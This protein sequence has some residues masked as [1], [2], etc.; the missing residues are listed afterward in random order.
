MI[1]SLERD[2][3][4]LS[5]CARLVTTL[6]QWKLRIGTN[7]SA[8]L[9]TAQ[10]R[11]ASDHSFSILLTT[12]SNTTQSMPSI[13]LVLKSCFWSNHLPG[14][15]RRVT[16]AMLSVASE[17]MILLRHLVT[18]RMTCRVT[19]WNFP[20]VDGVKPKSVGFII[21][22]AHT[23]YSILSLLHSARGHCGIVVS[24]YL[25]CTATHMWS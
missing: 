7:T 25:A 19:G 13:G 4:G 15:S 16:T 1:L 14:V 11:T 24:Y 2:I 17:L 9:P 12:W 21:L 20:G 6:W 3:S 22:S 23:L 10:A 5:I 8:L 18:T